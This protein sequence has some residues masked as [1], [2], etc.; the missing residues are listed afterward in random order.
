MQKPRAAK[1]PSQQRYVTIALVA[2]IHVA[3]IY[4]LIVSLN[5]TLLPRLVPDNPIDLIRTKELPPPPTRPDISPTLVTPG[6]PIPQPPKVWE[7]SN[8]NTPYSPP[9]TS[10][11]GDTGTTQTLLPTLMPA[12]AIASTHTIPMYPPIAARLSEQ[13]SVRLT[14]DIDEQG[15]VTDAAVIGSSGYS[16][17]DAAAIA[18][19]K[20][21]WRYAPALRDGVPIRSSTNAIV[22]FRLT[23]RQG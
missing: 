5:P 16:A 11:N 20:A 19:V 12:R 9:T 17:L 14:L 2:A 10:G 4:A 3:A 13:G 15:Y 8:P 22:T 7:D 23:D 18:W 6:T 1:A 21:H